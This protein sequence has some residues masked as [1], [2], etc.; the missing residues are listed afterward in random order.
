MTLNLQGLTQELDNKAVVT[1]FAPSPTGLMHMGHAYAAWVAQALAKQ[2]PHGRFLLRFE[3]IDTTRVKAPYYDAI[4]EDLQWLGLPWDDSPLRQSTRSAA[5]Q[6]ALTELKS[7]GV[8]YP[9]FCTRAEIIAESARIT[10]APHGPDGPSYPGTCRSLQPDQREKKISS[11]LAHSWRL[12]SIAASQLCGPLEFTDLRY[13]VIRAD[14]SLLGDVILSRK[15]IGPAYHLAVVHRLLQ[16]LLKLP[17]LDYLHHPL[18]A[19]PQGKRLAKRT[20]SQ[21]IA[22]LRDAGMPLQE[23]FMQIE[24]A[25]ST[26]RETIN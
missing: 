11:G 21:S 2:Y 10:N 8:V 1:R 18:V 17:A 7:L 3:D 5:Y 25:L 23:I 15:D 16:A 26:S 12:D 24:Q 6:F 9:C 4:E 20:D 19:D 13:G 14:P 22:S